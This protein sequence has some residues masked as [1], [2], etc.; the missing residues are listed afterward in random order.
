MNLSRQQLICRIN[1][2]LEIWAD[3][4]QF[5]LRR[6]KNLN[7]DWFYSDLESLI[8][9]IFDLKMKELAIHDN[10]KNLRN[11][12]KSIQGAKDFIHK[13]IGPMLDSYQQKEASSERERV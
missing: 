9:D 8:Q 5:I 1:E 3:D 7:K 10:E 11:L 12:G 6:D 2:N 4:K 13:V